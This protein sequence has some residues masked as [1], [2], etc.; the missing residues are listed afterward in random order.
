MKTSRT[1]GADGCRANSIHG[2]T[3]LWAGSSSAM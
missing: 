3:G 1:G 2:L